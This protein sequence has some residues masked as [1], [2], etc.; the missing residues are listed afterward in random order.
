MA[1]KA[2]N[3]FK[4]RINKHFRRLDLQITR[5]NNSL[6]MAKMFDSDC[7]FSFMLNKNSGGPVATED[8]P[9]HD[10]I[11]TLPPIANSDKHKKD[12]IPFSLITSASTIKVAGEDRSATNRK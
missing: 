4:T 9:R 6:G 7:K 8:G 1:K 12:S 10:P 5:G 2:D 3:P 11:G